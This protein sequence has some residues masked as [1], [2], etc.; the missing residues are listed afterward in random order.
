M[1]FLPRPFLGTFCPPEWKKII[2][3]SI[4]KS[5]QS[6]SAD[7]QSNSTYSNEL[8]SPIDIICHDTLATIVKMNNSGIVPCT[9]M[10]RL[11]GHS[12]PGKIR[13]SREGKVKRSAWSNFTV[14]YRLISTPVYGS[15]ISLSIMKWKSKVRLQY[16]KVSSN[17]KLEK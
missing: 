4:A 10:V 11:G 15:I 2:H 5:R 6:S 12:F 17:I 14:E 7:H 9:R 16:S 1:N 8:S 3:V 13:H